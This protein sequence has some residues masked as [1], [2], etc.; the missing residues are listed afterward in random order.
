MQFIFPSN[1]KFSFKMFGFIDYKTAI[2]N[3]IYGTILFLICKILNIGI[4]IKIYLF[5]SLYFPV[6]L[7][8]V[9][10]LNGENILDVLKYLIK[11]LINQKVYLYSKE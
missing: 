8:T 3:L 4:N 1:Y 6:L 2:F 7:F 5:V 10:G 9:F 11:F